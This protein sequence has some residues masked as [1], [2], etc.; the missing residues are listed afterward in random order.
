[1]ETPVL[2][3][4]RLVCLWLGEEGSC[5]HPVIQGQDERVLSLS[6][7]GLQLT[8]VIFIQ[9]EEPWKITWKRFLQAR[10]GGGPN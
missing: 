7:S 3:G 6:R 9:K 1:M 10:P 2:N 4:S 5:P 8:V